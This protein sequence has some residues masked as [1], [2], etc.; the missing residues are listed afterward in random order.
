MSDTNI[1]I[2]KI[3][4]YEWLAGENLESCKKEYQE[5]TGCTAEESFEDPH[6]IS[7]EAYDKLI[8]CTDEDDTEGNEI[9]HSFRTQLNILIESKVKFPRL[10]ATTEW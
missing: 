1:K 10:F 6:E 5:Q 3:N 4:D 2:F 8:Y 7:K 9:K